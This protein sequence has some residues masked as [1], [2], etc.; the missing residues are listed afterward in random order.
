MCA[1]IM[2]LVRC[3][4]CGRRFEPNESSPMP[5]CSRRCRTTDLGR[6]LEEKYGMPVEPEEEPEEPD[7][8]DPAT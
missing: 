7:S 1:R 2:S 4:I 3:P 6:W 8:G 5:F